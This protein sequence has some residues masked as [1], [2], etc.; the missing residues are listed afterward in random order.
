[1]DAPDRVAGVV[2]RLA[3]RVPVLDVVGAVVLRATT[4]WRG[5]LLSHEVRGAVDLQA[6]LYA[7][8]AHAEWPV[9]EALAAAGRAVRTLHDAGVSHA[10]LHPKNLLLAGRTGEILVIDLDRARAFDGLLPD[11]ERLTN[12]VRLGRAV[13]GQTSTARARGT[14]R[15]VTSATGPTASPSICS[16]ADGAAD[17]VNSDWSCRASRPPKG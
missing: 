2:V 9:T 4:G 16:E 8:Q 14:E 5:F 13:G 11:E 7:P 15:N 6:F 17:T 1:M 3:A 12:L 10:D